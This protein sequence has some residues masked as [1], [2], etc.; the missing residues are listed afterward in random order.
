MRSSRQWP[1]ASARKRRIRPHSAIISARKD[2][3]PKAK[4]RKRDKSKIVRGKEVSISESASAGQ[5][6]Y[7][8]MKVGGVYTFIETSADSH[9]TLQTGSGNSTVM[10]RARTAGTIG[11][12]ISIQFT[13]SGTNPTNI[14]IVNGNAIV[15]QLKSTSGTS[16]A[17]ADDVISTIRNTTASDG[18]V[19]CGRGDGNG[20]GIVLAQ[21]ATNL[22]GGGGTWLHQVITFA[23]HEIDSVQKLYLDNRE[24]T[25]GHVSDSRWGTGIWDY[26]AFMAVNLGSDSQTVQPDLTAQLPTRWTSDHR[27]R[28]CAHAYIITIWDQNLFAEGGI[29][30]AAFL[31]RGVKPY[32][33]RIPGY[34]YSNNAAL[35][36][37]D[38][39]A[40]SKFGLGV[41]FADIDSATLIT[42]AN[43]CD[44][45]GYTINGVFDSS[46]T[47]GEILEE[48]SAA[49][50]GGDIIFQAGKWYIYPAKWRASSKTLS[51]S[52]L[53]HPMEVSTSVSRS[54]IFNAIR[55]TFVNP[56]ADYTETDFPPQTNATYQ[57][58]DGVQLWE[59]LSLTFV[60]S[61]IRAQQIAKIEL[62]RV[63]QGISVLYPM[64]LGGL[65]LQVSDTVQVNNT[66][67]G[68]TNKLFE[69][70]DIV[71]E[72][73]TDG[74][75]T[76]VLN[77]RETASAVFDWSD[78]QATALDVSPN[79]TLPSPS[80]VTAP[81]NVQ[82]FSGTS[83]LYFRIDGTVFSRLR[84]QWDATTNI[85]VR[86]GGYF[87]IQFKPSSSATYSQTF[88]IN[89]DQ[90]FHHILDVQ[91]G[92]S[93]DVRMRAVNSLGYR[94]D[95][96]SVAGHVVVGK[97]APPSNITNFT[98]TVSDLG[99][100]FN[101]SAISDID[102]D[103]YEIR[104]GSSWAAGEVVV[105]ARAD[106][107]TF[108]Y[109]YFYPGTNEFRIKAIDTSGNYS[110]SDTLRTLALTGPGP[111]RN[112]NVTS[113]GFN[114]LVDWDEPLP[115]SLSIIA[116]KVY[117]GATFNSAS[118]LGSTA[119]TF[120]SY[121]ESTAGYYTYW[122]VP[123]DAGGNVGSPASLTFYAQ[124]PDNFY[125][126][127]S[128]SVFTSGTLISQEFAIQGG[129]VEAPLESSQKVFAPLG[130]GT[131]GGALRPLAYE[132]STETW[133]EWFDNAGFETLQEF[134]DAGYDCPLSPN[135]FWPAH[136]EYKYDFGAVLPNTLLRWLYVIESFEGP[137]TVTPTL[138]VSSDD[139]SYTDYPGTSEI[140]AA[141]FRYVKFR[142]DF[143]AEN[144]SAFVAVSDSVAYL[145]L[146][147]DDETFQK[148]VFSADAGGTTV[149]FVKNWL[150]VVDIQ[151]TPVGTTFAS[152]VADFAGGANPTSFK[153]LLYNSAGT[154]INGTVNIRIRGALDIT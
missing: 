129:G 78:G 138:S 126:E 34:A 83:E 81:Q 9:A 19:D 88:F 117:V 11:N 101:W 94:S 79:T 42:A 74:T 122:I 99:I 21:A 150:Y 14:I 96:V 80:D 10:L 51:E 95:W 136:I 2:Q 49:M 77:L 60:T 86:E 26:K 50:G 100:E 18:L 57:A 134:I 139:V 120:F 31:V 25:F 152:A 3:N 47:P 106:A 127:D 141:A 24:V 64:H 125:L 48:M 61:H 115:S 22:T 46:A 131:Q 146:Q 84:V 8:E 15:I 58:T 116:Y 144:D 110:S 148:S 113:V 119:G 45:L 69:V 36:I 154:R 142:L 72:L 12:A 130:V 54:D 151:V 105:R 76:C 6:I 65:E 149:N 53:R 92:I 97:T 93:Y 75:M 32:D 55:G 70:R 135:P 27:Q 1:N 5:V 124:P 59:D 102:V 109:R 143:Q 56:N 128:V 67:L 91:D 111:A 73:D 40:N 108:L 44:T 87:E 90:T 89:G 85:Y 37:A 38:Y 63:R 123:V 43:D 147:L 20:T 52:D 71:I 98:A 66:R 112:L 133:A 153:V 107:T 4:K 140:S 39:L 137:C 118:L 13:V 29:P 35:V 41:P 23:C 132:D 30:E 16:T 114:I 17:T 28:G 82:L 33:P 104:R 62:E 145:Q 103:L 121:I 7:G 68:W